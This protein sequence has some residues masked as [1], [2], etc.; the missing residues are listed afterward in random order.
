MEAP[1]LERIRSGITERRAR[2][3]QWLQ[4]SAEEQ[5]ALALGP[6]TEASLQDH[7]SQLDLALEKSRTGEMG[8]CEVCH[9]TVETELLEL[10]YQCCVCLEHFSEAQVRELERE[11]ELAQGVQRELL[12]REVPEFPGLQVAAYTRPAQIVSGDFFDFY[13]F[14]DGRPGVVVADVA[15]HGLSAS[16]HM[17]GLQSLMRALV[18]ISASPSQV[19]Q[20]IHKL[21]RHNFRFTT[22]VSV[23]LAAADLQQGELCYASAGHNPPALLGV[24]AEAGLR[25]DWLMPTGPALGL[26]EQGD[27]TER[28]VRFEPGDM[29]ALY[30][31]G[32]PEAFAPSGEQFGQ[33]RLEQLLRQGLALSAQEAVR[34]VRDALQTF[35]GTDAPTDDVTLIVFRRTQG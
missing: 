1:V 28:Q 20:H 19:L 21:Y 35:T 33:A 30:T 18:P 9:E 10:D 12:P 16:L 4:G 2:L 8:L 3:T 27:Y 31:D 13:Q 26:T 14:Q 29:L 6:M 7:L 32:I 5:R 25:L 34:S 22:F 15:G 24:G 11:L 23:F 17:A